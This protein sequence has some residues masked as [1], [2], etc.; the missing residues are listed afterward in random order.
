MLLSDPHRKLGSPRS[1]LKTYPKP[2]LSRKEKV[3]GECRYLWFLRDIDISLVFQS[4]LFFPT[5]L[6]SMSFCSTVTKRLC[7]KIVDIFQTIYGELKTPRPNFCQLSFFSCHFFLHVS[8]ITSFW[9]IWDYTR[10][11][12][13]TYLCIFSNVK[14]KNVGFLL[15]HSRSQGSSK[16]ATD[17]VLSLE[18][19]GSLLWYGFD[20]W[21]RNFHMLWVWP[22][23]PPPRKKEKRK[24][25]L[26]FLF[27]RDQVI[28]PWSCPLTASKGEFRMEKT[29]S[30][31]C[32]GKAAPR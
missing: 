28:S 13:S 22:P 30:I 3:G 32:F 11:D 19:L 7:V 9:R 18:R 25:C 29:G 17:L 16:Q 2:F 20:P 24:C 6:K 23:P 21:P 1:L 15:W 5:P 26:L 31:L 27:C 8:I 14:G 4:L 12:I 10:H